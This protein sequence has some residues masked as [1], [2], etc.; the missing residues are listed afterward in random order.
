[1]SHGPWSSVTTVTQFCMC[2]SRFE[3]S[4]GL[5]EDEANEKRCDKR[6]DRV[7]LKTTSLSGAENVLTFIVFFPRACKLVTERIVTSVISPMFAGQRL[8]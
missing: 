1:M 4:S 2:E 7:L 3:T 6:D 8:L 5:D